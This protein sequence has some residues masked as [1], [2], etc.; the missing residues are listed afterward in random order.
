VSICLSAM[1]SPEPHA[2]SLP[3]FV[4]VAYVRGSVLLRHVD[5]SPHR[6]SAGRGDGSVQRGRSVI[7]DCLVKANFITLAGSK[8]AR[9]WFG[10]GS[11]LVRSWSQTGSKPNSIT[12]SGSKL[13]RS[14][15]P[16][17]FEPVCIQL[18]TCFEPA[19][20]MEFGF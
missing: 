19:S 16:S 3:F 11:K 12:L 7:Y 15:S 8:L 6:Q 1:I 13:V 20:V 2:R 14:W 4:H 5:D 17:S 10:A 9:S 18:R